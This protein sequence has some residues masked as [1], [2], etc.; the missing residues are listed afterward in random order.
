[1]AKEQYIVGLDVGTDSIR[2]VQGKLEESGRINIIGAATV[3]ANGLRK[4]VIVDIDEAVSSISA[5]LEKVERMTGVP[6][7]HANVSVGGNHISCMD[8]KGVI[9]VSRADGEISEN[10]VIRVID[11]SQAVSIPPNREVIHVIP[12]TF[13]LDGQS[14]IKDPIGMTGIRLEVETIIIHGALPFLKNLNK[15][16]TQAGLEVDQL[17]LSPLAA[18]QSVL[19]KRQKELGVALID[20]G[21][22]TTSLAVYEENNL[23]HTAIIPIGSMHITNDIA[24]GLRCT[25][26]TA[27]KVKT[28][29]GQASP[30]LVD[31]LAEIDMS[32]IDPEEETRVS[33]QMVAEIIE[34]RLEEIFDRVTAELKRI[35]RDG[36]LPAGIVLTGGGAVMPGI[37]DFAKHYLRLPVSV[38]VPSET[39]TIIDQVVDPSFATVV[40]LSLWGSTFASSGFSDFSFTKPFKG[41][42]DNQNV[43][44]LKKWFKTIM[45]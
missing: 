25:I 9:A 32:K 16:I 42:I 35:D 27:E 17:V 12:K 40:G 34:A 10:D 44:K 23:I 5:V 41:L 21:A 38:G 7:Q 3:P 29:Y 30:A 6:V 37:V 39:D 4:G 20:L 26:D 33:Q 1:M 43:V 15:A 13:T 45:P 36:K 31:K 2:V 14:G 22:G 8:S 18:G 11:A 19:N 24:I 28:L